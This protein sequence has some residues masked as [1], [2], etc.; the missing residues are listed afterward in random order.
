MELKQQMISPSASFSYHLPKNHSST[1]FSVVLAGLL[2]SL[3]PI[4]FPSPQPDML[5]ITFISAHDLL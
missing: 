3:D 2:F 4:K 5:H 1:R